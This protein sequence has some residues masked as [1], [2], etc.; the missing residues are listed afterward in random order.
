MGA[1][2]QEVV[3]LAA[4]DGI[5]ERTRGARPRLALA[6]DGPCADRSERDGD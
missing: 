5:S 1:A 2:R 3:A 6:S 4:D